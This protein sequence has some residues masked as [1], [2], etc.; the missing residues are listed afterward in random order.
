MGSKNLKTISKTEPSVAFVPKHPL[1]VK[2]LF[3]VFF[4]CLSL[5]SFDIVLLRE[6]L[7]GG[8]SPRQA[9]FFFREV[10]WRYAAKM[11]GVGAIVMRLVSGGGR[12]ETV[13]DG[14]LDGVGDDI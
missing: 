2:H 6:M 5:P 10:W 12:D 14:G 13:S 1:F 8:F 7:A 3:L 9:V 4:L 11:E